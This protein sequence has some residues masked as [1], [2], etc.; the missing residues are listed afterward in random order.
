[1]D[2][3]V[4]TRSSHDDGNN[5]LFGTVLTGPGQI[6]PPTIQNQYDNSDT[7]WLRSVGARTMAGQTKP[8]QA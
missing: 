6:L 1:M 7:A 8:D 3:A 5:V 2:R 4:G